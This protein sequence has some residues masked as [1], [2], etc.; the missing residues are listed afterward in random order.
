MS[1][2]ILCFPQWFHANMA[3]MAPPYSIQ[4]AEEYELLNDGTLPPSHSRSSNRPSYK[5]GS[6]IDWLLEENAERERK[7]ILHSQR[8]LRGAL[9]PILDSSRTWLVT[10]FTGIC[11]GVAGAWLDVLVRW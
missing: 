6:T 11:I 3:G 7:R 5:D 2:R 10:I 9:A 8:G 4:D 1:F